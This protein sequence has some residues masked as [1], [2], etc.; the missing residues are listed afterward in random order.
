MCVSVPACLC[1]LHMPSLYSSF[2]L[3]QQLFGCVYSAGS[4]YCLSRF[5]S[6]FQCSRACI[7]YV[8]RQQQHVYI[9][10]EARPSSACSRRVI[11]P[12]TSTSQAPCSRLS[13]F[14]KNEWFFFF[15]VTLSS[16]LFISFLL[17]PSS[18]PSPP[19]PWAG[20]VARLERFW[21]KNI[22]CYLPA[23]RWSQNRGEK[24]QSRAAW[25]SSRDTPDQKTLLL[26]N[27]FIF[28]LHVQLDAYL[29]VSCRLHEALLLFLARCFAVSPCGFPPFLPSLMMW[30][31][32]WC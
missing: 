12:S 4:C 29:T 11:I 14:M 19:L 2:F 1:L 18:Q 10:A 3:M 13:L 9:Y 21:V 26:Q 8:A 27:V 31:A 28:L 24:L 16:A 20:W 32:R 22:L 5:S 30:L 23:R 6:M 15:F 25:T 7:R 17:A